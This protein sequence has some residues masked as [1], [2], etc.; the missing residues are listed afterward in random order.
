MFK[1]IILNTDSYKASHFLQ[2]PPHTEYVSSYI[3]ARG[4]EFKQS[5][6]FGLQAFIKEYLLTP[7]SQA[8]IEEAEALFALHGVP[9]NKAG[10]QYILARYN[11]YLPVEIQALPEGSVVPTHNA[12]VQIKNTD[13]QLYWLT[14]Y[15]ETALLRAIWYPT[16]VATVSWEVKQ[17]LRAYLQ[18]TSDDAEAQLPFKLHDFGARGVS[19]QES[20]AL[21]GMAHL[22]NFLGTDTVAALL[23]ARRY[24]QADMAGFSIPA[25]EHSTMTAWGREQEADA[26][27]NMLN[28]FAKPGKTVAVVSDSYDIFNAVSQIWGEQLRQQVKN[29]GATVVIRPDSGKPEIIVPDL[30]KRLYA[31]FGGRINSKGYIVLDNAVRLIQGDGVDKDSIKLILQSIEQ[32]GFSTENV[33]FGMGGGLLQKVNR[34]TLSFAMKASAVQINGQWQDAYKQPITD[35]GKTSKRGRLAVIQHN[36]AYQTLREDALKG[37][38]DLLRC[39]Y[40]NG[41]LLID[42]S[43]DVIRTRSH[44]YA[45]QS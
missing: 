3:E 8:D 42:E 22:V 2:Y 33:A 23:A 27:A 32:A 16:T 4:G 35:A 1:N 20:A 37:Q 6:F 19:S 25:T 17:T 10:W 13:P 15:L 26:Y 44:Q 34:D 45:I 31:S 18:T 40:R 30:L 21:G 38:T 43:F 39:V 11:G 12:L 36:N 28:Q 14:S 41:E 5:V 29:S 7:I 9:F 24:Y